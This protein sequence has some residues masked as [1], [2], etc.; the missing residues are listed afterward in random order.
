MDLWDAAESRPKQDIGRYIRI[1]LFALIGVA[2]F[3][4]VSNQS[5]N[6]FLNANEFRDLFTKP[7]YYAILSGLVLSSVALIRVDI[8]KRESMVWWIFSIGI[9]FLKRE[10]FEQSKVSTKYRDFKLSKQTTRSGR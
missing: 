7:I 4:I 10:A 9:S 2:I 8:R 6:I 3:G 1:G 5:V